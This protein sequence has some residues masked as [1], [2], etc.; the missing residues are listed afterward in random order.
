MAFSFL[1]LNTSYYSWF[2]KCKRMLTRLM[3]YQIILLWAFIRLKKIEETSD[4]IKEKLKRNYTYFNIPKNQSIMDFIE[5][6]SLFVLIWCV[7][8]L[9]FGILG[10]FGSAFGNKI[11]AFLFSI[12][13]LIY[14]NPLLPENRGNFYDMRIELF[15]NIGILF[16]IL[17]CAYQPVPEDAVEE[18]SSDE[19]KFIVDKTRASSKN[20]DES[21]MRKSSK[22]TQK[23]KKK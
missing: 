12:T 4:E 19:I 8:E 10:V 22:V 11:S 23:A 7:L 6:P 3:I 15:F 18:T 2:S 13:T 21:G 14:F 16:G 20:Y 17:L 1:K 9:I 5:D